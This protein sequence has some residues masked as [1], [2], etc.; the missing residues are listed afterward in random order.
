MSVTCWLSGDIWIGDT[1]LAGCV[2]LFKEAHLGEVVNT[3]KLID[4]IGDKVVA[5]ATVILAAYGFRLVSDYLRYRLD[6][7]GKPIFE[8]HPE[9]EAPIGR[10]IT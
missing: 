2:P 8:R 10:S 5:L 6:T 1:P 4:L 7:T 9:D 3:L